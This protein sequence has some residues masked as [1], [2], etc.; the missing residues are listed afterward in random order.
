MS[1]SRNI[2]MMNHQDESENYR[3]RVHNCCFSVIRIV[4]LRQV[5]R[6]SEK[7]KNWLYDLLNRTKKRQTEISS[8]VRRRLNWLGTKVFL[9][10]FE[11]CVLP[12]IRSTTLRERHVC[13]VCCCCGSSSTRYDP[14]HWTLC[15]VSRFDTL[16]VL[17]ITS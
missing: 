12:G 5:L 13:S 2:A 9:S 15:L 3:R 16:Q 14:L 4:F 11:L 10:Y 17:V 8:R 6:H 7:C 1:L